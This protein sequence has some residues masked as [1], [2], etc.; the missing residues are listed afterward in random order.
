MKI[1][2]IF[3]NIIDVQM[4]VV[5]LFLMGYQ[6]WGDFAHEWAGASMFSLFIVHQILN[7]NWYRSI[8]KG[9]YSIIRIVQTFVNFFLLVAMLSLMYSGIVLSNY[10]FAFLPIDGG[11]S[12]AR[13]LH[14]LGSYWTFV[15]M[16]IHLGLHWN[17]L[18]GKAKI[19]M[20]FKAPF[21]IYRAFIFLFG[22]VVA[23]YGAYVFIN[24]NL[25]SYLFLQTEFVFMDYNEPIILFY[26]DYFA[27]MGLWIF[28]THSISK[29]LKKLNVKKEDNK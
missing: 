15:L 13:R 27:M 1:K 3:K 16:S 28:I 10:V 6:F 9:S 17:M 23:V 19:W 25:L 8:F 12:L 14:I 4:T 5:L 7:L 21:K 2:A 24:R 26:L 18:I 29:R 20:R 22:A 11:M